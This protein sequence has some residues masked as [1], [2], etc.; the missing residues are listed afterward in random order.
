MFPLFGISGPVIARPAADE[1]R[2]LS[3]KELL[4]GGVVQVGFPASEETTHKESRPSRTHLIDVYIT[5]RYV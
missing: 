1:A 4:N 5:T 2:Q 3:T